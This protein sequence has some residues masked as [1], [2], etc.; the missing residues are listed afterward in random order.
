MTI[1][2]GISAG[3]RGQLTYVKDEEDLSSIE[4]SDHDIFQWRLNLRRR[5]VDITEVNK[6]FKAW[7][8][9]H[10]EGVIDFKA[11]INE[12]DGNPFV[13]YHPGT[14]TQ[15]QPALIAL[16]PDGGETNPQ[17]RWRMNG[18][19]EEQRVE[20]GIGTPNI[21][22]GKIRVNGDVEIDWPEPS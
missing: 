22:V 2:S 4:M 5:M 13:N 11:Y 12:G 19:I 17:K 3:H 20:V 10:S 1:L 21:I 14:F 16:W 7:W 8:Y 9:S 15:T 18:W 6:S